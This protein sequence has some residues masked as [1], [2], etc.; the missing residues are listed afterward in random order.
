MG[1]LQTIAYLQSRA[2]RYEKRNGHM[3]KNQQEK[4]NKNEETDDLHNWT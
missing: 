1:L 4:N 3:T 2:T